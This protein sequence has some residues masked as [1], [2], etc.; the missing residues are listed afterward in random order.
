MQTLLTDA[1]DRLQPRLVIAGRWCDA[2]GSAR[3]AVVN[4]AT[5]RTIGEFA[6]AGGAD[7]IRAVDAA[8]AALAEWRSLSA[9]QRADHLQRWYEMV[10][11]S[12]EWLATTITLEQGKPLKEARA[13]IDYAASFI[14]WFA[15]E[16]R[17]IYGETIPADGPGRHLTVSHRGIGVCAAIT[18]WNFPA[19][20]VTR[21]AAP[22]L[23]AGCTM[24]LKPAEQ[25]PLTALALARLALEAGIAPGV[26]NVVTGPPVEIGAVLTRDPR[27]RKLSFTGSTAVG[28]K[29]MEA[30][31]ST[32]KRLSLELGGNAPFLVFDDADIELAVESAMLAKFRNSGQTC[33]AANRF[34]LHESIADRFVSRLL[35]SMEGLVV[36]PG[37]EDSS[38]L[39]PLINDA[40]V[41]KIE[42]LLADATARGAE[43]RT[44]G[45]RH[46]LGLSFIEPT[47]LESVDPQAAIM[48][49]EV[50]GPVVPVT[51][52]R[53]EQEAVA[54]A[55]ATDSGLAAYV[56]TRDVSRS[57]RLHDALEVGMLGLN[58]GLVSNAAAPFGGIKQ[59]GFG[60]EGARQGI[61]EYVDTRL[62]CVGGVDR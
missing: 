28:K 40:A 35:R 30:C 55:N 37:I 52:F 4:P 34:L 27:I 21:K 60:R 18:P 46:R 51:T 13:E 15:E 1:D 12:R 56:H 14:R 17:R 62:L 61:Q 47:L 41:G 16:G 43:L 58:T 25:T 5:G 59:S 54:L 31:S 3:S 7:A 39:G 22:A 32:V 10:L 49:E 6:C 53:D 50:F 20:M 9:L 38:R 19:A 26:F 36:G 42:R 24:V 33:V 45:K 8:T 57:L 11:S 48:Q 23:A 29:L 2:E 44:G